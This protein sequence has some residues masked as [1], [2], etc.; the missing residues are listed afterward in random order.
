MD[1]FLQVYNLKNLVKTPT[2][3]K[4]PV[5]PTCIDL[6]LTNKPKCFQNTSVLETDLSD[7]H[8]MTVT[9][10][11]IHFPKQKP[12]IINYRD[13][14]TFSNE[15]FCTSILSHANVMETQDI[16]SFQELCINL[17][18]SIAPKKK[19]YIRANQAPFMNKM[20]QKAIMDRSRL[21]NKFL[22]HMTSS[23]KMAYNKQR[24]SCVNL[25]RKQKKQYYKNLDIRKI[26][27]NRTFWKYVKPAFSEKSTKTDKIT[28]IENNEILSEDNKISEIFNTYFSNLVSNLNITIDKNLL[29]E[30]AG[31]NDLILST[32]KKYENH[33]SI[34]A[35]KNNVRHDKS[36]AFDPITLRE[37]ENEIQNL[38]LSK[39]VQETDIPSKIIK[40]NSD[41]FAPVFY[42][43]FNENIRLETFP[44]TLKQASVNPI[45]KK[46]CRTSKENYRPVSI[47]PNIS[48]KFEKCLHRQISS[49][50]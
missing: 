16:N 6:L 26:T 27:D 39:V 33:P 15:E 18:N 28:L 48:K 50:F 49:F 41:I 25:C 7:C 17:L 20:L 37:I 36:F 40:E 32:I 22:K 19:K 46:G 24:N 8:K 14:R 29:S 35:I 21:R 45:F 44:D 31:I 47:L 11:K 1:E 30:E 43:C 10:L 5:K 23:N 3:F 34:K 9:V 12:K 13:Y 4:N 2:C 42:N 38:D